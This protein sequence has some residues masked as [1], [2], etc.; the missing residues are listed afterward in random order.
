MHTLR[1][2][3]GLERAWLVGGRL[4]PPFAIH[5]IVEA[6]APLD[7][8]RWQAAIAET[9][10]VWPGLRARLSGWLRGTRW[11]AEDRP[12]PVVIA[13]DRWA[14]DGPHPLLETRLL[15][16]PGARAVLWPADGRA[17][18]SAH[19][20]LTDGRGL[21]GFVVDVVR[22]LNREA[23]HGAEGGPLVDAELARQAGATEAAPA[24]PSDARSPF[25]EAPVDRPGL[26]W[27]RRR[28][29]PRR[30]VVA[31]AAH[32]T[33]AAAGHGLTI[34][35]PV[36]LRR[37]APAV[38]S[39]A[40]LTGV[41]G[42]RITREQSIEDIAADL[43]A[44]LEARAAARHALG[45]DGLRGLPLWLMTAIARASGRRTAPLRPDSAVISSL[46]R[47]ALQLD[48]EP[49]RLLFVPPGSEGLP[50]FMGLSGDIDGIEVAAVSP[51][52]RVDAERLDDW[53]DA[54]E[55]AFSNAAT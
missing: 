55:S 45:A 39:S 38:R 36:D 40:N 5:L 24:R 29:P 54:F 47:H 6:P 17:V 48:G 32:A 20:A 12:L 30:A 31:R 2:L 42:L 53:L 34:G 7:A 35:V 13:D 46:G 41:V 44:A 43:A 18:F 1:P 16:G 9:S 33:V 14:G 50:L 15:P 10:A 4:Y 51:R 23:P 19:H 21:F 25:G 3:S 49:L 26:I 37:H 8:D 28:L 27:R 22:A 52:A 11:I